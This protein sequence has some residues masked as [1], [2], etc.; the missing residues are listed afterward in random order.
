MGTARPAPGAR[1]NDPRYGVG[2]PRGSD[3]AGTR[4]LTA[5]QTGS[6]ESG[7]ADVVLDGAGFPDP[8]VER[9]LVQTR[10]GGP[11][12]ATGAAAVAD[13]VATAARR[14]HL[15]AA[16]VAAPAA[17]RPPLTTGWR[18]VVPDR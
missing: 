1:G 17:G 18:T 4:T 10:D 14:A 16:P 3:A 8:P 5:A 11:L 13:V 2:E 6:G 9:V 12:G 7:R 15:V